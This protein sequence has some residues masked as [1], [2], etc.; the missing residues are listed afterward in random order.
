M[1]SVLLVQNGFGT[2]LTY[3]QMMLWNQF[4]RLPPLLEFW[5]TTILLSQLRTTINKGKPTSLLITIRELDYPC[6]IVVLIFQSWDVS[7]NL[8]VKTE[9]LV[10]NFG[11]CSSSLF[12]YNF[13]RGCVGNKWSKSLIMTCSWLSVTDLLQPSWKLLPF[14]C[15]PFLQRWQLLS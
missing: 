11:F 3:H 13:T 7:Q 2:F 15:L 5:Q 12:G 6:L 10:R 14:L 8:K 9:C 1:G 4:D